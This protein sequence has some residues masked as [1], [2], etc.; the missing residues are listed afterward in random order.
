VAELSIEQ[1]EGFGLATIMARK[2]V[3][4]DRI[5]SA[6]GI[7]APVAPAYKIGAGGIAMIGT[8]P[9]MWLGYATT[10]DVGWIK[11][12][13]DRLEGIASVFDQSSGYRI[14]RLSGAGARVVLQRGAPIDFDPS[15]FGPGSAVST[16]ISHIGVIVWQ[17]DDAP[18]YEIAVF[19]SFF[20]SFHHWLDQTAL[21]L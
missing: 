18:T 5:G 3:G 4:A 8:G 6:L 10:P 1:R 11:G 9:G 17:I 16:V 21:A 13:Q 7:E 15:V 20:S 14:V 2:G 12:L 19:R